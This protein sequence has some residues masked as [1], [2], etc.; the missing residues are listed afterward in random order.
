MMLV[1]I[2]LL[3]QKERRKKAFV[4]ALSS[5]LGLLIFIS[6][7]YIWQISS[8]KSDIKAVDNQLTLLEKATELSGDNNT[9]T[10]ASSESVSLLKNAVEWADHYP[11]QTVPVMK[12]MT[13]LLPERGFIQTFGYTESGVI[14]LTVQFDSAR[15]A[16]YFLDSLN[17]SEWLEEANMTTLNAEE[18][19]AEDKQTSSTSTAGKTEQNDEYL[20]RYVGQFEIKFDAETIKK[21]MTATDDKEE[22]AKNS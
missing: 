5:L 4:I 15:E 14:T 12:H 21:L 9:Q 10:P 19:A 17:A 3:P 20:P 2:N 1:E 22:G 18:K 11:L 16:A 7:A 8:T 6:G 13:S